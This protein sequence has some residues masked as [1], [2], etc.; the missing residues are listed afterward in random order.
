VNA[1]PNTGESA[2]NLKFIKYRFENG[3]DFERQ[4][5]SYYFPKVRCSNR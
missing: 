1:V 2:G 5:S 3:Y 4:A